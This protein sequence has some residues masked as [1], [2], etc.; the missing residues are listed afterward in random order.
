M[1]RKFNVQMLEYD[2]RVFLNKHDILNFLESVRASSLSIE[3]RMKL[4]MIIDA[5]MEVE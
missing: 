2:G 5:L 4:K 3:C 1:S